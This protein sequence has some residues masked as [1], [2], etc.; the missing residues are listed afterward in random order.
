[1]KYGGVRAATAID[2][3][4][5]HDIRSLE[6]SQNGRRIGRTTLVIFR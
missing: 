3:I 6:L 2:P 4:K 1:M 5:S